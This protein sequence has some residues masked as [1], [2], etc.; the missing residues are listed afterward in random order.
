ME[1]PRILVR[2]QDTFFNWD[3]SFSAM[4]WLMITRDMARAWEKPRQK[5]FLRTRK[6]R[7]LVRKADLRAEIEQSTNYNGTNELVCFV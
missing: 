7:T 6:P 1:T 3:I 4:S 5:T 2:E